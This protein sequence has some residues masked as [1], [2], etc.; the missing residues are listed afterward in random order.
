VGGSFRQGIH[1]VLEP[2]VYGIPVLYGPKHENSQEAMELARRG[3]SFVITNAEECY[4]QLRRMLND[5]KARLRAGAESLRLVQE[6]VGATE[7]F[8]EYLET[9]VKK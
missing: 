6:N 3:G 8:I 9:A 4:M 2:A 1:N 5:K 7:R